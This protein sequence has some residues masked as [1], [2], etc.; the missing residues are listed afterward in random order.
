MSFKKIRMSDYFKNSILRKRPEFIHK[1]EDIINWLNHPSYVKVQTDKRFR[2]YALD[3]D[4][5]NG[6]ESFYLKIVLRY[7]IFFMTVA[8]RGSL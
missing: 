4:R 1:E 5:K 2:Y 7:T 6:C 8:L 3:L